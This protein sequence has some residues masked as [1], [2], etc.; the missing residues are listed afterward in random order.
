MFLSPSRKHTLGLGTQYPQIF[1]KYLLSHGLLKFSNSYFCMTKAEYFKFYFY[2]HYSSF[3]TQFKFHSLNKALPGC[4]GLSSISQSQLNIC[5]IIMHCFVK[6]FT[7][8][9]CF[10]FLLFTSYNSSTIL[11]YICGPLDLMVALRQ[12]LYLCVLVVVVDGSCLSD[13]TDEEGHILEEHRTSGLLL[14]Q[15]KQRLPNEWGQTGKSENGK[16]IPP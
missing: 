4:S 1:K 11:F 9:A 15:V 5:C 8:F 6:Q 12:V 10:F 16:G 13:L 2:V 7:Q 14:Q 3:K